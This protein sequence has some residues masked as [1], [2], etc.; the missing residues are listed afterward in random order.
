MF[1]VP[2]SDIPDKSGSTPTRPLAP[3]HIG[4]SRKNSLFDLIY[5]NPIHV[6]FWSR[7]SYPIKFASHRYIQW[8]IF[9]GGPDLIWFCSL[10]SWRSRWIL[11][12]NRLSC[13][14]MMAPCSMT[15]SF[16]FLTLGRAQLV[17]DCGKTLSFS[18]WS[19]WVNPCVSRL[20]PK[21]LSCSCHTPLSYPVSI[22]LTLTTVNPMPLQTRPRHRSLKTL[23]TV[24]HFSLFLSVRHEIK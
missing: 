3:W 5:Y 22:D 21:R 13:W 11:S 23:F 1:P 6:A 4:G 15:G 8:K 2:P 14:G 12:E 16:P 10:M 7:S 17:K 18:L 9:G 20:E 24:S 19:G